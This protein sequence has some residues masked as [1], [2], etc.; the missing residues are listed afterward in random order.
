MSAL[1]LPPARRNTISVALNGLPGDGSL[2]LQVCTDC[3]RA[4]YPPRELCAQCLGIHLEWRNVDGMA[5][6][7]ASTALQHS[8]EE[9]FRE[10]LPWQVASLR[11]DAG[12]VVLAHID[13]A[14]AATGTRVRVANA[15]D[16]SGSWI[17]IA[18]AAQDGDPR[19]AL[20]TALQQLRLSA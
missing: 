15:T 4:Q 13:A 2:R 5:T 1:N 8:L 7:L 18:C 6:V 19:V 9:F 17:L 16:A 10:R 12:P 11:L 3:L 14:N 20:Q